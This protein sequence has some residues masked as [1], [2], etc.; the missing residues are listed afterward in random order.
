[1]TQ[2]LGVVLPIALVLMAFIL[3]LFMDRSATA[4]LI[5]RSLYELPVDVMFLALS[6]TTAFTI[7]DAMHMGTGMFHLYVFFIVALVAVVLWRRSI[8]LFESD[9]RFWSAILFVVNGSGAAY[10]LYQAI[11]LLGTKVTP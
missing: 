1:M 11:N 7:A 4:P 8:L 3:K 9:H 6:F 2:H 10:V 5:I